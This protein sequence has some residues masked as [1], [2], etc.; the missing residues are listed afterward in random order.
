MPSNCDEWWATPSMTP[1]TIGLADEVA[2]KFHFDP[3]RAAACAS[4]AWLILGDRNRVRASTQQAID[5]YSTLNGGRSARP[6]AMIID[7]ADQ[8][9]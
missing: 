1:A 5:Y 2:G 6:V 4:A 3:C 7:F 9:R 8:V